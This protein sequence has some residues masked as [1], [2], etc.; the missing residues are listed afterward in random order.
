MP[1]RLSGTH[2]LNPPNPT[3]QPYL[4]PRPS[5]LQ[6][7]KDPSLLRFLVDMRGED[8]TNKQLRDD[9]MTMLIAGHET[10]AAV[11]TWTFF[12]IVQVWTRSTQ[13]LVSFQP[14][15]KGLTLPCM[16][17]PAPSRTRPSRP[18]CSLRLTVW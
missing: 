4:A 12:C 6:Q 11:L 1:F 8:A 17:L 7:V 13:F 9:L 5:P 10:T 18:R 14:R 15:L 16:P 2:F 3:P